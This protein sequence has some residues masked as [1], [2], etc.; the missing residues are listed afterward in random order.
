M[1]MGRPVTFILFCVPLGGYILVRKMI[2]V[3]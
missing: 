1:A 3:G 2:A